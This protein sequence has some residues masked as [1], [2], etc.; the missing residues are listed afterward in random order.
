MQFTGKWLNAVAQEVDAVD[1][2]E[3]ARQERAWITETPSRLEN[4]PFTAGER[5]LISR[6]LK[7]IEQFTVKTFEL[8]AAQHTEVK[9]QLDYLADATERL[10]RF[11]WR[12]L[13]GSTLLGIALQLGLTPER[14]AALMNLAMQLLGPFV[15]GVSRLLGNG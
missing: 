11:D 3:A 2:W 10:G 14:A 15:T 5:E 4:T 9:E 1:L 6:H 12:G 13:A 8:T 7:T